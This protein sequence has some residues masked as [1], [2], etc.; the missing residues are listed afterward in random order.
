M[1]KAERSVDRTPKVLGADVELGNFVLGLHAV[2]GT[3]PV[4]SRAL[5]DEIDGVPNRSAPAVTA[6]A[7]PLRTM[8]QYACAGW[9]GAAAAVDPQDCGRRFLPSNGGCAYIDLDHLELAL[10]ETLSAFDHV[11]YWR[12][13]LGVARGALTA[14]NRRLPEGRRLQVLVNCSD[15]F[16]H[17]YGSHANVLL[18]RAAWENII[19]RKPHYLAYLTAFQVSSIVFTGQGKVGSENDRPHVDYQLSQRADF[20]ETLVSPQTT[21]NRPIVNSRDEP[22]CG[23]RSVSCDAADDPELARLHVIFFDS[24]LCQTATLLR[25]G[26]L[27]I[28]VAML[29]AGVVDSSLALDD[30][31]DALRVWSGD[32]SLSTRARTTDGTD[33]TAV[34]LQSRFLTEARRFAREGGFEGVVPRVDE[35]LALWEDTLIKLRDRDFA[36]L[37][38]RLDWV[39]KLQIL[40]RAMAQHPELSWTSPQI[41]HLDQLYASLDGGDGLFWACES[42]GR[43]DRIVSDE[44]V[45]RAVENPPENTR[46][47][48]RAHVMRRAGAGNIDQVDWDLVAVSVP[49]RRSD[50]RWLERRTVRLPRPY[51]ATRAEHEALFHGDRSLADILDA[52]DPPN[53]DRPATTLEG[54]T[55]KY[56]IS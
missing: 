40:R 29:E 5:L 47:W 52:L 6:S 27:Q 28:V 18:T 45:T 2:S 8:D 38:R 22:L 12:A 26:T 39:L 15:G 34:E 43:V 37:G 30:P 35:I 10:P 44:D 41:K 46:A 42:G 3:G 55:S 51:R 4:A 31:L 54:F 48:T 49:V 14:A 53:E 20:M 32:P 13:M 25:A 36:V 11:A 7:T 50:R 33:L 16:G 24:T 19:C 1:L 23:R 9:H 56:S 21:F 17:S